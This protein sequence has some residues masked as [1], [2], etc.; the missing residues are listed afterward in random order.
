MIGR[1]IPVIALA[2]SLALAAFAPVT[3][4]KGGP[5]P[6]DHPLLRLLTTSETAPGREHRAILIHPILSESADAPNV[7]RPLSSKE[8]LG[9]EHLSMGE[10]EKKPG[11]GPL[12]AFNWSKE[13]I[14]LLGGEVFVGGTRDR[15]LSR[16]VLLGPASKVEV[17]AYP[18]DRKPRTRLEAQK[19]LKPVEALAPDLLRLVGLGG[20]ALSAA[21]AFIEDEYAL[22]G[23]KIERSPLAALFELAT[24]Q[25]RMREYVTIFD[26]IPDEAQRRVV[27]AAVFVGDRL[28]GVDIFPTNAAFRAQW[29]KILRTASFQA[30]VHELSYGLLNQ[31]YPAGRLPDRH[32]QELKDL[33]KKCYVARALEEKAVGLGEEVRLSHADIVGRVLT[34]ENVLVHAVLSLD[35]LRNDPDTQPPPG[36]GGPAESTPGELERRSA[37]SRLTEYERR[38]LERMRQRRPTVPGGRRPGLGE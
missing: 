3:V 9:A 22:T 30:S 29:G 1:R 6:A 19:S 24:L 21:D 4:A 25:A 28:A 16:D 31:V 5:V 17:P 26:A 33:L 14:L 38:L 13:P 7:K 27:G 8:A 20:G 34:H 2:A 36:V 18:A 11:R 23:T 15:F 35:F 37:R 12:A 32:L 10:S